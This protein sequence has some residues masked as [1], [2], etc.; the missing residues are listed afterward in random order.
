MGYGHFNG[1][2]FF[3][4]FFFVEHHFSYYSNHFICFS[5]MQIDG[6][7]DGLLGFGLF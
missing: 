5:L 3:F 1:V 2:V 4:F 6:W 7:T